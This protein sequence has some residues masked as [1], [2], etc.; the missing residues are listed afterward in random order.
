MMA[1]A[2][3]TRPDERLPYLELARQR[4]RVARSVQP[5]SLQRLAAI[6][7][8]RSDLDVE[9]KFDLDAQGRPWVSGSAN[10]VLAATCQRCMEQFDHDMA[11]RFELCI[12]RDPTL[13]STLAS[14]IDVLVADSDSVAVADVVED[15]LILELP[16]RLC[17][18][19]PCPY[20][21]ALAYPAEPGGNGG[22]P[23][24]AGKDESNPFRVLS[25]LKQR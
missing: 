20:A 6:A 19:T 9:M 23:E 21:P 1:P 11:V 16:D 7:P 3:D 17:T 13:A 24:S 5:D 14:E 22:E 12:V 2:M 25:V 10:V 4:A 8:G 15:E 18:E